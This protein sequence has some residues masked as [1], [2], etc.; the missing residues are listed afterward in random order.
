MIAFSTQNALVRSPFYDQIIGKFNEIVTKE[1]KVNK[2]KF[3]NEHVAQ[4]IPGYSKDS[5]YYFLK[6]FQ[7]T[8]TSVLPGTSALTPPNETRLMENLRDSAEATRLGIAAAINIGTDALEE[9]L[10]NPQKAS[11]LQRV[12]LL[13]KAMNAQNNRINALATLRQEKREHA[14]FQK[15]FNEAAYAEIEDT[16]ED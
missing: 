3:F 16:P 8:S 7:K 14:K 13:F 4:L 5:F 1:G 15:T 10:N 2:T 11:V 12:E 9:I 6:K